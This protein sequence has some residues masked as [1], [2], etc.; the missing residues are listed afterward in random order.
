M[1]TSYAFEN[2]DCEQTQALLT[3]Y[4]GNTLSARQ[5]WQVE[6]HLAACAECARISRE[7]QA[8]VHLLRTAP[9]YDTS[10]DFMAKLH[11]RLD[12]VEPEAPRARPL[13]TA[14][15]DGLMRVLEALRR[16]PAPAL[17]MGMAV[18]ALIAL[19]LVSRPASDNNPGTAPPPPAPIVEQPLRRNVALAA[20]N[21]L[22]DPAAA[23][24][25]AQTALEETNVEVDPAGQ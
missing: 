20:S 19:L 22:D 12:A 6:K 4:L 16:R 17:G 25:E 10:A 24:L 13:L 7:M 11:A 1:A 15:Q 23:N 5:A 14:A 3:D 18:T 9:R 8:T 2:K 21:P